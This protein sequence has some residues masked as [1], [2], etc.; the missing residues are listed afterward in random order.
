MPEWPESETR[1]SPRPEP[2]WPRTFFWMFVLILFMGSGL[3]VFKSCRDLPGEAVDKTVDKTV[4]IMTNVSRSLAELAASFNQGSITVSLASSNTRIRDTK[5]FQFKTIQQYEVFTR[6]D[7][8]STGF[9]YIPLPEVIVEARA[10]V[11]YNYYL[12]LDAPWRLVVR[13][14]LVHVFTPGIHYNRPSIDASRIEYDIRKGSL[15]RDTASAQENLKKSITSLS[16][17]KAR[18]NIALVRQTG[19]QSVAEFVQQ[20]L[21]TAFSDGTN[22]QVRIHFPGETTAADLTMENRTLP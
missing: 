12:N 18:E 11:E 9:G 5:Y 2:S 8:A 7:Q 1:S 13:S 16:Y 10:P 14:N 4:Q 15:L 6:T 20:W 21:R 17:L 22:Y 3:F 19:R